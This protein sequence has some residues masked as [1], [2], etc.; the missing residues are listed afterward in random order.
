MIEPCLSLASGSYFVNLRL[1][2][3]EWQEKAMERMLAQQKPK[4][5][6]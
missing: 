1:V 6:R 4:R 5:R 3:P 2:D